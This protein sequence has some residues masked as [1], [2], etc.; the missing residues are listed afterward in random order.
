[1]IASRL[2]AVSLGC[3]LSVVAL[4]RPARAQQ[5]Q[6]PPTLG[7]VSELRDSEKAGLA[8]LLAKYPSACGK[9]HSLE[10]SLK[11]DPKCRR[12]VFAGRYLV[13]LFKMHL[14]TSE[15]EEHYD[16]RFGQTK[17]IEV[18]TTN[19][20]LRG[21]AN[22]PVKI[23]EFSDFQCPHCKKLQPALERILDEYRG[24]VKLYFKNYPISRMHPHAELAAAAALAAGKQGKFWQFHDRIYGGDQDNLALPVLEKIAKDLKLDIKKWRADIETSK[25][26]VV[27]DHAD[28]EKI[29]VAATPTIIINGRLYRGPITFDEIKDWIDEELNR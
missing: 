3:A 25:E 9:A 12:S 4:A 20:P 29:D 18:D 11:S 19:A 13:K 28:G 8:K 10:V 17:K 22:A 16:E 24:Q 23:V 27:R 14:L 2:P 1:M 21:D 26:Q 7:D 15:V 5:T 6:F